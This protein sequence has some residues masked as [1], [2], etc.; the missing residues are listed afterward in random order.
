MMARGS[1]IENDKTS[2][3]ELADFPR[4]PTS[5]PPDLVINYRA[6]RDEDAGSSSQAPGRSQVPEGI[7]YN[8][9]R[10]IMNDVRANPSAYH[11]PMQ[12]NPENGVVA[13]SSV[14]LGEVNRS[15]WTSLTS[16]YKKYEMEHQAI[17]S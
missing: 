15:G 5:T 11:T 16:I 12:Q 17:K 2:Q 6:R 3:N 13:F 7:F 4:I 10:N 8:I 14:V 9:I 1:S